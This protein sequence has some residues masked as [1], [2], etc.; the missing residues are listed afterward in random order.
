MTVYQVQNKLAGTLGVGQ[1]DADLQDMIYDGVWTFH[2]PAADTAG[3]DYTYWS[4]KVPFDVEIVEV[5]ICPHGTLTAHDD[6]YA[7]ITLEKADG[8]AGSATAVATQTTKITGGSGDWA[9]DTFEDVPVDASEK[10]VD[11]GQMLLVEAV[12]TGTGVAVPISSFSIRYRR[13]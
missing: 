11:D 3:T 4:M 13:R 2:K 10:T 8:A 6:N 12:K 1:D 9:A 7:T 5:T